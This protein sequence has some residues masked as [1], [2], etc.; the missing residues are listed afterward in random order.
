MVS[1]TED[2]DRERDEEEVGRTLNLFREG[3]RDWRPLLDVVPSSLF[4][5]CERGS[6]PDDPP[7]G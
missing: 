5:C 4:I 2:D 6:S 3:Y 7:Y 1:T